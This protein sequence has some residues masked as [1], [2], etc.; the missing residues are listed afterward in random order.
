MA[1]ASHESID[2]GTN[3]PVA[4]IGRN[5]LI[6]PLN[7]CENIGP[8]CMIAGPIYVIIYKQIVIFHIYLA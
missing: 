6:G 7:M 8:L 2:S 3:N 1:R 4:N 5:T